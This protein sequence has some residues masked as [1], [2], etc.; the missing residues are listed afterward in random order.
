VAGDLGL[1]LGD[2]THLYQ[3][4]L[5]L[6]VNA[7]D[8]MPDGGDLTLE[9]QNVLV[10]ERMAG[11]G[12]CG[13]PGRHVCLSISDTGEGIPPES[14]DRIFEPFF[15]TKTP[16]K[17]TG[18]G[19]STVMGICRSHGGFVR[20]NSTVGRGSRFE[21]YLPVTDVAHVGAGASSPT[22]SPLVHGETILVVDDEVAVCELVR[23]V[24]ERQGYHVLVAYG[25]AEAIEVFE[26]HRAIIQA[27]ITDIMMPNIDGPTLAGLVR[28]IDPTVRIIGISG[29]GDR[30]MLEKIEALKLAGF[31]PKPFSVDRLLRVLRQVLRNPPEQAAR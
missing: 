5:N 19:L 22:R 29:A 25:G 15:T 13:K 2:S 28:Q 16:G 3:A 17:G 12:T 14:L 10:N 20:V 24:L 30:I 27:M 4:V 21:L 8:A 23:R 7:R 18:L 31:L 11:E 9:A 6:C 1:I 26:R